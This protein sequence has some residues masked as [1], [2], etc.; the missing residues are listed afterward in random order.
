MAELRRKANNA[1]RMLARVNRILG[2][3]HRI[4]QQLNNSV[5]VLRNPILAVQGAGVSEKNTS[6][7]AKKHCMVYIFRMYFLLLS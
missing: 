1:Q 2:Q 7:V 4:I 5:L 6:K 3:C